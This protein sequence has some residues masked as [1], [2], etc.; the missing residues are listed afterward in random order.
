MTI[1]GKDILKYG[2]ML[3]FAAVMVYFAF[4]KLSWADFIAGLKSCN[5]WWI[6]GTIALMWLITYLRGNRWRIMMAP[7]SKDLT[8]RETYDAYALC[9]LANIPLPRLGEIIRCGLLSSTGKVTFE[10][11]LGTVVIERAWD[12]ICAF[13]FLIPLFFFGTFRDFIVE[14]MLNPL[15]DSFNVNSI[16]LIAV[17]VVAI[18][19]VIWLLVRYRNKIKFIRNLIDGV[20]AAFKMER[21]WLFFGYTIL[22]WLG[23][24]M[25]S[26]W[27][28]YAF[29]ETSHLGFTDAIFVM[30]VGSLGWMVP[31]QGGFGAYHA[32]LT[33]ALEAVYGFTYQ[34]GLI[35]ATIS[36]ES[37]IVQM[38]LCGLI[39]LVSWTLYKRKFKK[40][41]K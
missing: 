11:A 30:T 17:V 39:S 27:T 1:K 26:L 21:K 8:R 35:F 34:T 28:I 16:W 31:V 3:A 19:V 12:I 36:H 13:L 40:Q 15:A 32:I 10:G 24:I 37:Q 29:P 20:K 7:I 18:A 9:Y 38:I 2:L 25:T 23:Y 33:I 22:I 6:I 14:K 41:L 4:R 5:Y